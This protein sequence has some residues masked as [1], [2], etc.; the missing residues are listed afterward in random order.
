[1]GKFVRPKN[2]KF[3]PKKVAD[4]C[5]FTTHKTEPDYKDVLILRRFITPRGKILIGSLTS[6]TAKNQ[7]LLSKAIKN[8]RF[9]ALLPYTDK[10]AI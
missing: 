5:Y 9:M 10:H 2:K 3:A 7:R 1:M 8:A 4:E 6:L